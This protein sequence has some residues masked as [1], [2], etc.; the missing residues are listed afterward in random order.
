MKV[1]DK[2]RQ[3]KF[4]KQ[5]EEKSI[6]GLWRKQ[7][8]LWNAK[9]N[10]N[11]IELEKPRRHGYKRFFILRDDVAKGRDAS[12]YR[13][14]L[15]Y[16]QTFVYCKD[17]KF[18]R[19]DYK[20]K[21]MVPIEQSIQSIDHRS[22]NKI[23]PTLTEKQKVLFERYWRQNPINPKNGEWRYRFKKP[24][25]FVEKI[26]PH[27]ITHVIEI[28]PTLE[29]QLREILN[30]IEANNMMPKINKM[31]GWNKNYDDYETIRHKLMSKIIDKEARETIMMAH[32]FYNEET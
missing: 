16:L 1:V 15:K 31:M 17:K 14:L 27:Y 26:E 9:R 30:K 13:P 29:S 5:K 22:Y 10:L 32:E 24:W 6:L 3:R 2:H 25:M 23:E 18:L 12:I 4:D 7:T 21:K 8:R 28:D 11:K 20:T 19:K